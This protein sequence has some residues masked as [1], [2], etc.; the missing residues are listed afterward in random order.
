MILEDVLK[1]GFAEADRDLLTQAANSTRVDLLY[2]LQSRDWKGLLALEQEIND[3]LVTYRHVIRSQAPDES[4]FVGQ[5]YAT[6][7]IARACR[8]GH[9]SPDDIV[10]AK[11]SKDGL[12]MLTVLY[13]RRSLM[14]AEMRKSRD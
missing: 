7:G 8:E 10:A 14:A 5:L 2:A 1:K 3:A 9:A 13:R 4:F 6:Q 11:R 12:R